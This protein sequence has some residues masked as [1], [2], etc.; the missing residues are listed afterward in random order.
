MFVKKK[1]ESN[2]NPIID[3]SPRKESYI[4]VYVYNDD[5]DDDDDSLRKT[6]QNI[7]LRHGARRAR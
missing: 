2:V 3:E 7:A 1:G 6:I 5:D 4:L